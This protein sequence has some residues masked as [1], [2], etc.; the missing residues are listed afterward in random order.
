MTPEQADWVFE[1]V[2]RPVPDAFLPDD[3]CWCQGH[4]VLS[5]C[6]CR[7]GHHDMCHAYTFDKE[8]HLFNDRFSWPP[9][10][11]VWLAGRLCKMPC[12]CATCRP[13]ATQLDLFGA[14]S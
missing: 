9:L 6:P 1:H 3:R 13:P 12:A 5:C 8:G 7:S 4:G 11:A 10:A 14:A 2:L